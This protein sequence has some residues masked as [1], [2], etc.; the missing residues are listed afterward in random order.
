MRHRQHSH[1]HFVGI[2]GALMAGAARIALEAGFTVSGSDLSYA[3]PMGDM[4]RAL[5]APLFDGYDATAD[6]RPADCYVIGNAVSRGNPLVESILA[7]RRPYI[8][9]AQWL[10]EHILPQRKVIA[11]AGTHGKTTTTSLLAWILERA[12][13]SPGFLAGGVIENF[14]ASARLGDGEWFVVEADEYD[15][16]FFDKRPKFLHYRPEIA[17]LNNLEFDHADIYKNVAEIVRQ[18]HFLLRSVPGSGRVV[19]RAKDKHLQSAIT[20]GIYSPLSLFGS[21]GEWQRRAGA[22]NSLRILHNQ[23]E[24]CKLSPPLFGSANRDN[25][26]AAAAAAHYAGADISKLDEYLRDFNPPLRRLQKIADA[27]GILVYDDFAHHP[28]AYQKTLQAL[29]ERH[30][31]HRL[32]AVFEPRSNTMK[33]GV[34]QSRLARAFAPADKVIATGKQE[35]LA[36]ALKPL[37][38]KAQIVKDAKAAARL[39]KQQLRPGDCAVLMSNGPFDNLP[40]TIAGLAKQRRAQ[41]KS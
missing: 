25:I 13:L 19:A 20:Q 10:G 15:S 41:T 40:Q 34:F 6:S 28:T 17:L 21:D 8:S 27:N 7:S 2:S 22:N 14:G 9:A 36:Q 31:G 23:K 35:W 4:A 33:A 37:A 38:A 12:G 39:L 24:V 30:P 1:L 16:A 32:I 5:N 26:L 11:V 18:F 3:P 29:K